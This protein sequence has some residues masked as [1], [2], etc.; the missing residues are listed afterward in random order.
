MVINMFLSHMYF[1]SKNCLREVCATV[2]QAKPLICT[3]EADKAKGGGPLD[4]IKAEL[5]DE[6]LKESVFTEERRITIWYRI[7]HC[8]WPGSD[9]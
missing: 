8:A 7:Y 6:R 1:T 4:E 2:D 9:P 3:H 5:T